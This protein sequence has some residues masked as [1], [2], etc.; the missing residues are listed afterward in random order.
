M[1][2]LEVLFISIINMS[3]T[4]SYI[5]LAVLI[6]RLLLKKAPKIFSYALWSIV[7]FRLVC[8]FSFTSSLSLIGLIKHFRNETSSINYIPGNLG[9]MSDPKIDTGIESLNDSINALLPAAAPH[10]SV[11]PLQILIAVGS[12]VWITGIIAMLSYALTSYWGLQKKI[13]TAALV[14]DNIYETDLIRS[15]FVCG[16]VKPKIYLPLCLEEYERNYILSHEQTHIKRYDYLVKPVVYTVLALHWFNPLM[17][18]CFSLMIKDMEMSCD[19]KVIESSSGNECM[20]YSNSLLNLAI[21]K[22]MPVPS[23]LA[24][25]ESNVKLRI[26]NVLHYKKPSFRVML[27]SV[28]VLTLMA[29][30]LISNPKAMANIS[31]EYSEKAPYDVDIL[32]NN[33]TPYVGNN[34]KVVALIDSM[35]LPEGIFRDTVQLHTTETPFGLTIHYSMKDDTAEVSEEQFLRNAVLLFALVDNLDEITHLGHWNNQLLSSTKFQFRYTREVA[36]IIVGGDIRKF[37]A[38]KKHLSEL[39][40]ILLLLKDTDPDSN[41]SANIINEVSLKGLSEKEYSETG[42]HGI[43]NPTINDFKKLTLNFYAKGFNNRSINFPGDKVYGLFTDTIVWYS[44]SMKQDNPSE[45]FA[46]YRYEF[47]LFTRNITDEDLRDRLGNL[48]IEVSYTND[49][50]EN[51]K[52]LYNLGETLLISP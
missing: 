51:V 12:L 44:H 45:D 35:P 38:D 26:K 41:S 8:P 28:I 36:N 40:D 10:W 29:V 7:L 2:N 15:P 22:K 34:V 46:M 20:N 52:N 23:P 16:L 39:I 4:A 50:G 47:I 13:S 11:N 14:K 32:I 48:S 17:W 42:T 37:A 43:E 3:I 9:V 18:L 6:V 30:I 31:H 1:K 33:K 5:A 24:F 49:L 21:G 25:G 27:I 19:E